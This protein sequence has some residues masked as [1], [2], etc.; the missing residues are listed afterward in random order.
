[1][2]LVFDSAYGGVGLAGWDEIAISILGGCGGEGR[3]M[4]YQ[5]ISVCKSMAEYLRSR[6]ERF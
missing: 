6:G 2:I 5:H 4:I 1:M 3:G